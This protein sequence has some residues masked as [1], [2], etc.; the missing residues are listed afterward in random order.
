M[1][2]LIYSSPASPSEVLLELQGG[3]AKG[4]GEDDFICKSIY[5]EIY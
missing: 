3:E 5:G 1:V 2:P 4:R